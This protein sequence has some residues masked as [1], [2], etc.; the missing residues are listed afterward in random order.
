MIKIQ[1]STSGKVIKNR[2]LIGVIQEALKG[3]DSILRAT[4][5]QIFVI[6]IQSLLDNGLEFKHLG[7]D[8]QVF[9]DNFEKNVVTDPLTATYTMGALN[10]LMALKDSAL[11]M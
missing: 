9:Y 3:T 11:S 1:T 4:S 7:V 6:L 5:T 2:T 8:I 10:E